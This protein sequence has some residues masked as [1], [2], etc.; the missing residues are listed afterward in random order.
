MWYSRRY[1]EKCYKKRVL[2]FKVNAL[3]PFDILQHF[4]LS[5]LIYF[6]HTCQEQSTILSLFFNRLA[7]II[8]IRL[9]R[10]GPDNMNKVTSFH[11][12]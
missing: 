5:S 2:G 3:L 4:S 12:T 7:E 8:E 10:S 6:W 9:D 11:A 1:L